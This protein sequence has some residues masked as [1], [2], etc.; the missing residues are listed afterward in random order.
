VTKID[1]GGLLGE[2][3]LTAAGG[4]EIQIPDAERL[5][6]L[7]FRRFAGCAFCNVHLRS[8][9][10]RHDE[11]AAAGIRE[12]VVFRSTAEQLQRYHG[13][14]PYDVVLDPQGRLYDEFGVGSGLRAVLDPRASLM[15]LPN[16][17]RSLFPARL[18]MPAPGGRFDGLFGFPADFLVA[19]DGRVVACKYG[20]HAEDG[21]SVD[22]LLSL[23]RRRTPQT[24]AT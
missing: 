17:A 16:V 12:V 21:W 19:T 24:T 20:A 9:E 2:R 10:V 18:G 14:A 11:I 22:E 7:Q 3:K 4:Q 23:A 6:H 13:A 1:S 8:F 5:V 15:A